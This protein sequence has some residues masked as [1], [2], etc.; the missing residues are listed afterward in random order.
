[1]SVDIEIVED[2]ARA[3]AAL[4]VGAA[5]GNGHIV[6]TGGG[7]PKA[8]YGHFVKAVHTVGVDLSETTLWIG[9]ERCVDVDDERS[10]YRMIKQALLDPLGDVEAPV[11][12]RM[13]G[14]LGP[15]DGAAD[16][17][18]TIRDAGSPTFDLLL[19][20]IGPDGHCASLFPHQST[21]SERDRLVVAVP[22]AGYEP[23][24]PRISL[25]FPALTAARHVV[26]LATG[27]SKAS[28][29]AHAFGPDTGPDPA[30]PSSYVAAEAQRVTVLV[31]EAAASG[32]EMGERA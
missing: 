24:V 8:A 25:T 10:N 20:G 5:L 2:P 30:T 23:F 7:T 27:E 19:L 17:E 31:D 15:E 22:E 29:I 6:L 18:R 11:M 3:C 21:L 1:M 32:L 12:H 13:K 28:A 9:D 14:E 26:F 4:M 16:Y